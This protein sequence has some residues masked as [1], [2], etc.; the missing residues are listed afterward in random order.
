GYA[1]VPLIFVDGT[2]ASCGDCGVDGL[3]VSADGSG[4]T[5]KGLTIG[6]FDGDGI[7]LAG[8]DHGSVVESSSIGIG[9]NGSYAGNRNS[10]IR[11][12]DSS[13][14]RIG[15]TTPAQRV[16]LG[17]NGGASQ[18]PQIAIIG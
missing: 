17:A 16:A 7:E 1:G 8:G 6:N 3:H 13:A 11:I 18:A 15:G 12:T 5:I 10:G 2:N 9:P 4:S 14:N